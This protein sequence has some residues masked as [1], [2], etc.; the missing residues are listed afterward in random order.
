MQSLSVLDNL[1][2]SPIVYVK[3]FSMSEGKD[4]AEG[5]LVITYAGE[6]IVHE[7][8]AQIHP[9]CVKTKVS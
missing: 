1:H 4:R 2:L 8:V 9:V 5:V 3:H 7:A 6:A